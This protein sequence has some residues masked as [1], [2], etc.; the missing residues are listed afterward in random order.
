[1]ISNNRK[2]IAKLVPDHQAK[3][4]RIDILSDVS[5]AEMEA[6]KAGTVQDGEV[7][8]TIDDETYR[9][10]LKTIRGDYRL[11]DGTTGNKLRR[12]EKQGFMPH[13][14]DVFQERLYRIQ[15]IS[16]DTLH[17]RRQETFFA[18]VTWDDLERER[19]V[20]EIVRE[21]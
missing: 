17:K 13:P 15:W 2:V 3:R 20:K 12:W 10:P 11:P 21:R 5:D 1:M 7:V 16:K 6:A 19:K 9:I 14:D 4:L 8:Y 18:S